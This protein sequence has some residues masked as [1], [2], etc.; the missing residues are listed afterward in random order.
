MRANISE[1]RKILRS[2]YYL[3]GLFSVLGMSIMVSAYSF[4]TIYLGLELLSLPLIC[5][6]C[7]E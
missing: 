5:H 7:Y 6:G 4:L 1:T 3:L 2:E